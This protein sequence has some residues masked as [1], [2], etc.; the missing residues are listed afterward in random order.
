MH[1]DQQQ[2]IREREREMC[3]LVHNAMR[4]PNRQRNVAKSPKK[5]AEKTLVQ[6]PRKKSQSQYSDLIQMYFYIFKKIKSNYSVKTKMN[7]L[8]LIS[9]PQKYSIH[10]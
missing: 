2:S 5:K 1:L 7:V 9:K 10:Q 4:R 3:F 6:N 8:T